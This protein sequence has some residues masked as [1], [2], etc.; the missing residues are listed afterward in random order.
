VNAANPDNLLNAGFETRQEEVLAVLKQKRISEAKAKIALEKAIMA[1]ARAE[2]DMARLYQMKVY[3]IKSAESWEEAMEAGGGS[4]DWESIIIQHL[5]SSDANWAEAIGAVYKLQEAA[6]DARATALTLQADVANLHTELGMLKNRGITRAAL[7]F[8]ST[9]AKIE[10]AT[11]NEP[12]SFPN[13][14]PIDGP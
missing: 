7:L 10:M 4:E 5:L 14:G 12:K 2:E 9:P 13:A 6:A 11:D 3:E 1:H 8:A